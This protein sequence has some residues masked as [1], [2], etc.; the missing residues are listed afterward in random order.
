MDVILELVLEVVGELLVQG[1][2]E[3]LIDGAGRSVRK[4]RGPP[5]PRP[6]AVRV[7]GVLLLGAGL[8][9]LF[10]LVVPAR[11]LPVSAVPGLSLVLS[12]LACGALMHFY[13][14]WRRARGGDTTIVATF[15]GGA[16][17][18]FGMALVRWLMVG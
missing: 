4:R 14:R 18:A 15:L 13:G 12:P 16:A 1:G 6:V 9:A 3:L 7:L 10:T 11:I 17:F 5:Q 8:G 2:V